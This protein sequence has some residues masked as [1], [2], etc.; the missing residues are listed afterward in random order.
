MNTT[1]NLDNLENLEDL[2]LKDS[3]RFKDSTNSTDFTLENLS[4][5]KKPELVSICKEKKL[6]ISGTKSELIDRILN[7]PKDNKKPKPLT[8]V[9][10]NVGSKV[11]K[12]QTPINSKP[13]YKKIREQFTEEKREP[14]II[15]KNIHGNFEHL[16][17]GLIFSINKKVI[18][19]QGS[20]GSIRGLSIKD[21][22][23]VY[24]YHFEL[25]KNIVVNDEI[26]NSEQKLF[27]SGL[28]QEKRLKELEEFSKTDESVEK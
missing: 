13:I 7:G 23:N 5:L 14:I 11:I 4:K 20:D 12:K 17:T 3:K 25:E 24:K 15:K 19:V 27:S 6:P 22:E 1:N 9:K 16:D 2:N 18:G 28:E 10:E 21:I 26:N 8:G